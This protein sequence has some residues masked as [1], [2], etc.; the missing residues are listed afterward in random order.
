M[1][2]KIP[3][4]LAMVNGNQNREHHAIAIEKLLWVYVTTVI[5]KQR[6]QDSCQLAGLAKVSC[7]FTSWYEVFETSCVI[8]LTARYALS[9]D[10]SLE[11]LQG[12]YP[13]SLR[14]R[15]SVE[16]RDGQSVIVAAL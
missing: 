1:R 10:P 5:S 11:V 7:D 16:A 2:R 4:V 14:H 9:P 13:I 8:I 6:S 12:L 15:A 3:N